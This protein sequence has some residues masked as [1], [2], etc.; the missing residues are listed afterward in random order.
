MTMRISITNWDGTRTANLEINEGGQINKQ[1]I[2]PGRSIEQ[3]IYTG[4]TLTISEASE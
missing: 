2:Q 3:T 1:T 4:K